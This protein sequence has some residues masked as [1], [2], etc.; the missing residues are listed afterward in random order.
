MFWKRKPGKWYIIQMEVSLYHE[1]QA[2]LSL[3]ASMQLNIWNILPLADSFVTPLRNILL[4]YKHIWNYSFIFIPIF[5]FCTKKYV[6]CFS[7]SRQCILW[8][9]SYQCIQNNLILFNACLL[10]YWMRCHSRH[11]SPLVDGHINCFQALGVII[12][13]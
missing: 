12:M 9:I 7:V 4:K 11:N 8:V 1:Y 6:A 5:A 2:L 13:H 10:C 3:S